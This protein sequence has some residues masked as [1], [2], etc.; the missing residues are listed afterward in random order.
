MVIPEMATGRRRGIMNSTNLAPRCRI[1]WPAVRLAVI[2]TASERGRIKK[3]MDSIMIRAGISPIG[4]PDG[5]KWPMANA[6]LSRNPRMTV[7]SHRG[8]ARPAFKAS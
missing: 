4:L 7:V 5:T 6:A 1:R 2:R 8:R 3:L